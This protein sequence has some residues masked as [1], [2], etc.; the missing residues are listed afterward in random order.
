MIGK[1]K[2]K[3]VLVCFGA[4][5][6]ALILIFIFSMT[7]LKYDKSRYDE[8]AEGFF[9][10]IV[11]GLSELSREQFNAYRGSSKPGTT[12]QREAM[13]SWVAKLGVL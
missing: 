7:F 10:Q 13:I 8:I 12:E 2:L 1:N 9:S 4:V 5:S 11:N 6:F 3:K